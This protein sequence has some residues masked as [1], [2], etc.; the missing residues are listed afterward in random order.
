MPKSQ[1]SQKQNTQD[2]LVLDESEIDIR[3]KFVDLEPSDLTR[4]A[5][6][7]DSVVANIDGFTAGFFGY[8]AKFGEAKEL[9]ASTSILDEAKRLKKDHLLAMVSGVYGQHYVDESLKLGRLYL[10]AGLDAKVF[11]GA[12]HFLMRSIAEQIMREGKVD[13][14]EAFRN[15]LAL[16]KIAIFDSGLII[17][18]IV[19]DREQTIRHQQ[20]A[21]RELSTPVLQMRD[22]LL[23]LPIVGTIDS[24][25]A[26]LLT[27]NLL[28]TIRSNRAKVV[29]LD[30]TGVA[31]VDSKVANHL[32]QTVTA[33]RLMGAMVIVT[34]LSAEIAQTL[35]T[36]GVDLAKLNTIGDL[37]GGIE[38]A[39]R[40]LGYKVTREI[41]PVS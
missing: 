9:F 28:R 33:S 13:P 30:I 8:I 31:S 32:V 4:I 6:L 20:E 25:R 23:I 3:L 37:E 29:V 36:I 39:E 12:F 17:D 38:E 18:T 10:K 22:R 2:S 21:I 24:Y 35:V 40:L 15:F 11:L 5:A 7:K 16:N 34:G 41:A 27:E 19:F 26:R 14:Q 1:E